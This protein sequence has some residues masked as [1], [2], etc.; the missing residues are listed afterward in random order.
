MKISR[1]HLLAGASSLAIISLVSYRKIKSFLQEHKIPGLI[2]GASFSRG[3]LIRDPK[4]PKPINTIKVETLIVGAGV[5]GLSAAYH[6]NNKQKEFLVIDLERNFGG[7]ARGGENSSGRYPQAAHYL[8]IPPKEAWELKDFLKDINVI[9]GK[10]SEG[11]DIYNDY[12][13]CAEPLERLYINGR[14]QNGLEPNSGLLD[15]EKSEMNRF[16]DLIE[17]Y[18]NL[19]GK[20]NKPAFTLPRSRSSEDP[21]ILKL[22][23]IS[24]KEFILQNN[25][26]LKY[27]FWYI[28]YCC[29]D[30]YGVRADKV[31]A[32][33]GIHYFVSRSSEVAGLHDSHNKVLTWP[34]GNQFLV[35]KLVEKFKDRIVLNRLVY[36]VVKKENLFEIFVYDFDKKESVRYFSEN[37]IYAAPE[38]TAKKVIQIPEIQKQFIDKKYSPWM[39]ANIELKERPYSEDIP[40]S[41]DNVSYYGKSLGHV[42]SD[43]QNLNS[44]KKEVTLTQYWPLL[45]NEESFKVAR[46]KA[47]KKTHPE[48]CNDIIEELELL[49]P[50]I[51]NEIKRIDISLFGH[52]M[53]V[54]TPHFLDSFKTI[55]YKNF[56]LAHTDQSG[57]SLFE[58]GFYQGLTAAKRV[59]NE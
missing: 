1:R 32:W 34:E 14:W 30:D 8:P 26:K 2:Q 35:G 38:F 21:E 55:D 49:Y 36:K 4:F 10:N 58:E 42:V 33:A 7:N 40:L 50:S 20:D 28:D 52:G 56:Y 24:F 39:V 5:S 54:P 29:L 59:L 25:F 41:W 45:K 17:G 3:H 48:W 46:I 9:T 51:K 57:L 37:L 11:K 19:I 15:H 44:I 43:H 27:L 47:L 53:I 13:L 23:K 16:F 22:D 6:L 18:Q 12:Y 31:S